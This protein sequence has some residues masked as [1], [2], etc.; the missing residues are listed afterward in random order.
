MYC[1]SPWIHKTQNGICH[2]ENHEDH[3]AGKG[4][5]SIS[6]YNKVHKFILMPHVMKIPVAKAAVNKEWKKIETIPAEQLEKVRSKKEVIKEAQKNKKKSTLLH[7]WTSVIWRTRS[8][9]RNSNSTKGRLVLRAD[10]VKDDSGAH[11]V[12]AEQGSSASQMTA[13]KVMDV[14]AR[15][16]DCDGQAADAISAL[17]PSKIGRML[18]DRLKI[19]SQHVQ[20]YG[21]VFHDTNGQHHGKIFKTPLFLLSETYTE[22]HLLAYC[23]RG[24]SK[25][26]C[27]NFTGTTYRIGH[28]CLFIEN[29]N[30]FDRYLWTF[31]KSLERSR[32]WH[33]SGRNWWRTLIFMNLHHFLITCI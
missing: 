7:W 2:E 22:A 16:P 15:L 13:A 8:W 4:Q 1:G 25:K 10:I 3:I 17:H 24:N 19:E 21:F 23:G 26:N 27:W 12:F 14:I 32:I 28:V 5:N 33:P 30:Y 20:K 6:H 29:N 9:S 18:Q 11:A 31:I